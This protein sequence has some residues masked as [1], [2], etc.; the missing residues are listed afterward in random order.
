MVRRVA[1]LGVC[2]S[3]PELKKSRVDALRTRVYRGGSKWV[4]LGGSPHLVCCHL[5]PVPAAVSLVQ[6]LEIASVKNFVRLSSV[7]T[8]PES[9][10]SLCLPHLLCSHY[11]LFRSRRIPATSVVPSLTKL[12]PP[13]LALKSL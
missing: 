1:G 9:C 8:L 4:S 7:R 6:I 3:N 12:A 10:S 11:L 13:S 2:T 5:F